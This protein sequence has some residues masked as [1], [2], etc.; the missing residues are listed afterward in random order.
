MI[1]PPSISFTTTGPMIGTRLAMEAP[2]PN[3]QYA[4]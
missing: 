1:G 2:I 4:S 3:P